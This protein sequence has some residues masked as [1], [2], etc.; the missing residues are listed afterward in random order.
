MVYLT[1]AQQVTLL[2][3]VGVYD[4]EALVPGRLASTVCGKATI[5]VFRHDDQGIFLI[6]RRSFA[7][8]VWRLL[9]KAARPYG[10]GIATLEQGSAH[11]VLR[12]V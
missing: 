11:P 3:H 1:G 9:S 8:Y 10:L 6:F 7:D 5:T 2:R 12:L 4:F